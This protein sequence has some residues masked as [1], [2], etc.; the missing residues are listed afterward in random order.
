M[1][2]TV[3]VIHVLDGDHRVKDNNIYRETFDSIESLILHKKSIG[4]LTNLSK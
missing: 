4:A 2:L 3:Q 1:G